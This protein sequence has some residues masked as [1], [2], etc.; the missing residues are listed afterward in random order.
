LLTVYA[1]TQ[2]A[3]SVCIEPEE[4]G[5]TQ[6]IT[7][8]FLKLKDAVSAELRAELIVSSIQDYLSVPR[9]FDVIVIAN[10][11]NHVNEDACVRLLDD[12]DSQAE[13]ESLFRRFFD[14]LNPGGW[15]IA[16]D[17][18]RSNFFNDIGMKSPFMPDIEWHKHQSPQTWNRLLQRVGFASARI[19]WSAPNTLGRFGRLAFGNRMAAYFL[20]S[21]FRLSARKPL[22]AAA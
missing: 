13:Y 6:G 16:T 19:Q 5:S 17:C 1:A 14:S 3:E 18:S 7:A 21:H 8:K 11:I 15:L 10:A 2:G 22:N 9:K 12:P 4:H 20:L